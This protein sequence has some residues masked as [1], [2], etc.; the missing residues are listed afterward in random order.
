[1]PQFD[2][3]SRSLNVFDTHFL[4]ASAGTGKTFAIEHLFVRLL[5]EG[6][7]PFVLEKILVVT[8]TR[9][10]TRELKARIRRNLQEVRAQLQN[11]NPSYDYLAALIESGESAVAQASRRI[12][13]ALLCFDNAQIFTLHSFCHRMLAEFAFEAKLGFEP[14]DPDEAEHLPLVRGAVKEF[15]REKL[16]SPEYSVEQISRLFKAH[17][18]DPTRVID[19]IVSV[20]LSDKAIAHVPTF[21]QM[22]QIFQKALVQLP[23]IT[24]AKFIHDFETLRPHYKALTSDDYSVQVARWA[25]VLERRGCSL[26]E[27]DLLIAESPTF[28]EKLRPENVKVRSR[29][30]IESQLHYPHLFAT[31]RSELLPLIKRATDPSHTLL[32]ISADCRASVQTK[33]TDRELF[34]PDQILRRLDAALDLPSFV[35]AVRNKYAAAIVDEFQDTDPVQWS[36]LKKL[37][38]AHLQVMCLV[39]DPKQSI[40]AF[41]SADIYTYLDAA[42]TLGE[43]KHKHLDVNY[44]STPS[45]VAALNHFFALPKEGWI[46]LPRLKRALSVPAV[47][48]GR[49]VPPDEAPDALHFF[50]A[51]GETNKRG[52]W[53]SESLEETKLFPFIAN[54]ILRLQQQKGL[55]W[56]DFAILVKDRFQARRVIDALAISGIPASFRRGNLMSETPAFYAMKELLEALLQPEDSSILKILLGGPLIGWSEERLQRGDGAELLAA[57]IQLLELRTLFYQKGFG[58]ALQAFFSSRFSEHSVGEELLQRGQL[59]LYLEMQ[60]LAELLMEEGLKR[61]FYGRDYLKFLQAMQQDGASEDP[62]FKMPPQE[63]RGSVVIMTI[64]LSKGLEFDTVFALGVASRHKLSEEPLVVRKATPQLTHFDL[65]DPACLESIAELDAEKLRHF[66]VALTRAKRQL[67]VPVVIDLTQAPIE[68]GSASAAE[69]FFSRAISQEVLDRLSLEN[70]LKPLCAGTSTSYSVVDST[71]MPRAVAQACMDQ[72]LTP[73][74]P[75]HAGGPAQSLLSF[76]ALTKRTGDFEESPLEVPIEVPEGLSAHTLPLGAE[77]G[78]MIHT[79]FERI[80]KFSWHNPLDREQIETLVT[81][82]V[83]LTHFASWEQVVVDLL[84]AIL[85]QPFSGFRLCDI[86][87]DQL[88]QEVEFLFPAS[89]GMVKGFADLLFI[90]DNRYYLLDWKTNFLG[91]TDAHY[92]DAAIQEAMVHH[93]YFLQASIYTAALKRYVKLFDKRPFEECFGGAVYAF[94]RGKRFFHFI[95][96]EFTC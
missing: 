58:A 16:T 77:T 81:K 87:K 82:E 68:L 86:P 44:R 4:E 12:E 29:P 66:Y 74:A 67:Y 27:L 70:V 53:P 22:H 2:V 43:E 64:H 21:D 71:E 76:T 5:I 59:I 11:L 19:R 57:R 6:D 75:F 37:F 32:Q 15:V 55:E 72:P 96:E 46:T 73:P 8:F 83:Q 41:R 63:E 65:N 31:L 36:I 42:E 10:A 56:H 47:K 60:K 13:D 30:P 54:E 79:L 51:E 85:T 78:I 7:E 48:A 34:S 88:A 95:P 80:F 40:Y 93:Q 25:E 90:Y 89:L 39:G 38:V 18:S 49:Q 28:L 17:R 69:L 62:R 33:L 92:T 45:L 91:P 84:L 50:I 14:S 1:M 20:V 3:L 24:A 9:A 23:S 26:A 35:R 94:V 52:K 61:R